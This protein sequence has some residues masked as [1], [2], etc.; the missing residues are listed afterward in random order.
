M[1]DRKNLHKKNSLISVP[2]KKGPLNEVSP[3]PSRRFNITTINRSRE[4]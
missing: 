2:N 1:I 4:L 3:D